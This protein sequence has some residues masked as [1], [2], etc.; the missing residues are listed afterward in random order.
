MIGVALGNN[1]RIAEG[2]GTQL[3]ATLT[4]GPTVTTRSAAPSATI[5]YTTNGTTPTTSSA[6]FP[7]LISVSTTETL[8][9]IAAASGSSNSVG[10]VA[11]PITL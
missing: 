10:A 11:T 9:S 1:E 7:E 5:Y 2:G 8:K 6:V 4:I 3:Q